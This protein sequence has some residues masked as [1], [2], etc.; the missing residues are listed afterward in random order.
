[1]QTFWRDL[2]YGL[3]M[4]AR[5][6]G[7]TAIAVLTLA[8]GIGANTAIF[9]VVN[10]VLLNPLP[11]RNPQQLT[12]IYWK[13]PQFNQAS[14]TFPNF[15][16]W[17]KD[18]RTFSAMA[19]YRGEDYSLTGSGEPERVHGQMISAD[20]FPLLGIQPVMGRSFR[21]QEDQVGAAPVAL[22]SEGFWKRRFGGSPDIL[23]RTITLS[24]TAYTVL[25][26][27][28][29][30]LPIFDPTI[31]MD[32]FVPI[33]QWNDPTFRN[34]KV[35]MGTQGVG[36]L[37]PGVTLA[38]ARADMASIAENLGAA[39]PDADKGTGI[40]VVPLKDDVVGDVR[41]MLLVL[42]G[43]VGFVLLIACANVANL[44]LARSTGRA[45]EFAVRA[46]LG[47][48]PS[49]V[50]RQLITESV[51]L[52]IAGGLLGVGIA[53]WGTGAI[54]AALPTALPRAD[55]IHLNT[56]VLLF[57]LAI[58]VFSGVIF[59]LAPAL[60]TRHSNLTETLKEGGRGVS[61]ARHRTQRIF[62]ALEMALA[63]ILLAGAGLMIRSLI[64][65]WSVN[66]GF[67][68]SHVTTFS[69]GFPKQ[70]LSTPADIRAAIR[71]LTAQLE[72]IPG[73][74]AA[75]VRAGGLPMSGDSELPFW[76]EGQPKPASESEMNLAVWYP[77]DTDYLK[78]MKIPLLRGRFLSATDNE[79]APQVVVI[80]DKFA[81]QYFP[82]QDPIGQRLNFGLIEEQAEIVGIAGH[83]KQW[84]LGNSTHQNLE[85]QYYSP[86]TQLP[87]KI[88]PL[89]ADGVGVV[90]RTSGPPPAFT[91]AIRE[92]TAKLDSS[93]VAYDFL[94]MSKI[95]TD[96]IGAQRLAM[97]LLGAFAA[98]ALLLSSVGIYGVISYV[99]SQRTHEIGV[100]M[101]L[102]AQRGDVLRMVLG[103]GMKV[104]LVGVG[105]GIAAAL[106]L[107]RL[108]NKMIY[109][110]SAA[111]P[112]TY[113]AVGA[114][115][116]IVALAA[117]YVPAR[118]AVRVDPMIALRYE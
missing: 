87:D 48:S 2:R 1:M 92:S 5:A 91:A 18:N 93:E 23:G 112:I 115:L 22:L 6:P 75:S 36:R 89:V 85:A 96:S 27:F 16:D 4:L 83:V 73:V 11:F 43:A 117:C 33:G 12:A 32:V 76:L 103:E 56:P 21:H 19:A 65:L 66:P 72:A 101:A 82:N 97:I 24:G 8:L 62:V 7:F 49:R 51:L 114:L 118:R 13:T 37:R 68:P 39:Y 98:L 64:A 10:G 69:V 47:A 31:P 42:V 84:G 80:D 45:R 99:A 26:V 108:M 113:A 86:L 54:L 15:L 35:G 17:Q 111:D 95:V 50:V 90:V 105:V 107:T 59:G 3:R 58:S 41:G 29:A 61:G 104:A 109:G 38:Q 53:K 20:F 25:G 88:L 81:R 55:N 79:T 67:D 110:V 94:P 77:V 60:R 46:A 116:I 34:R 28:P 106:G 52:A 40:A 100:R 9:S 14:L 63:V 57:T 44:L 70:K 30:H 71:D 78:V 74:E 102:G